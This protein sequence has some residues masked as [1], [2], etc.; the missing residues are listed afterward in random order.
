MSISDV[1]FTGP[2]ARQQTA[3]CAE[4][5]LSQFKITICVLRSENEK[6]SVQE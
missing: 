5:V 2:P 1:C 4:K 3:P 6:E